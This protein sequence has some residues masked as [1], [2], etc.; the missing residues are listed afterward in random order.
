M[1]DL[2]GLA[3]LAKQVVGREIAV[4]FI[5]GTADLQAMRDDLDIVL[6]LTF[7]AANRRRYP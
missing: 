3:Q 6:G 1:P 4:L 7:P 5:K 2:L